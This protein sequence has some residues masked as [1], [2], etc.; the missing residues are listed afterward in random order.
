MNR[1]NGRP[2]GI[3]LISLFFIFGV[4][5]SGLSFVML[6]RPGTP[7]EALWKLNPQAR[8]NLSAMANI[9]RLLMLTVCVL[10]A[11][12]AVGLWRCKSWGYWTA[13]S[14]LVINLVAD[15]INALLLHDWRTLIGL[16]IAGLMIG[17]L[18]RKRNVIK[19]SQCP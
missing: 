2:I 19:A 11:I 18:L 5:A 6:L 12:A 10:C 1:E 13:V 16:P 14:M 9:A 4:L 8:V 17:Y 15:T 7:L 3:S